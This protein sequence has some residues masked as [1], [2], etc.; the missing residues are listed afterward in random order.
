MSGKP[1]TPEQLELLRRLYPDTPTRDV[2]KACGHSKG[3]TYAYAQH[4]GL[5]KSA[6]FLATPASGRMQFHLYRGEKYRYPKG[7]VPANKGLRRPGWSPGRMAETQ[8]KKGQRTNTWKPMG[9]EVERDGIIWV[10]VTDNA[11]PAYRNWKSKHQAIWEAANGPVPAG[12]LVTFKDRNA[13]NFALANLAI[14]SRAD[15][16]RR[17]SIYNYPP[18]I[19][20]AVKLRGALNRQINKRSPRPKAR[21]GRPPGTKSQRTA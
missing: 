21:I 17:N 19:V 20:Q 3:S 13:R 6:A 1:W 15:N 18:E 16:L 9:T 7:H 14:I 8:F 10:K 12:H 5:K 2:A 11:K 4:F